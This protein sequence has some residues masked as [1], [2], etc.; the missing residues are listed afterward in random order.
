[1]YIYIY[2]YIYV[3]IYIY[4]YIYG[5]YAIPPPPM[6]GQPV[7]FGTGLGTPPPYFGVEKHKK[8]GLRVSSD[9][10][11]PV[12][13]SQYTILKILMRSRNRSVPCALCRHSNSAAK[14]GHR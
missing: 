3:Y 4:I 14:N 2:I 7:H 5:K 8:I 10:G 6:L 1:M 9:S 11:G 13:A 12:A